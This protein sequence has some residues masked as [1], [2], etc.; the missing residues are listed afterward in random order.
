MV[1]PELIR[2]YSF[3]A[4]LGHQHLVALA[5]SADVETAESG[6]KFFCEGK[7]LNE[8]YLVV[9]GA[10]SI[11][12]A[13][14]DPDV[15]QEVSDQLTGDLKTKD[16]TVSTVGSGDVFGWSAVLPPTYA[17]AGATAV[18]PCRVIVFDCKKLRESFEED[19]EFGYLML[20]R[21]AR[22]MRE[23]LRDVRI[24]SLSLHASRRHL[25]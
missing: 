18:T 10:V 21:A 24:E 4:G 12:F 2:R 16:V 13:V 5:K 7:E 19:T 23:R 1:S 17:T 9:E 14:P 3:F 25:A 15:E 6:Y 20:Q 8:F 11:N 22:V